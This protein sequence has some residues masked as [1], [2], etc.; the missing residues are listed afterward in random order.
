[1]FIKM[2]FIQDES[3][4]KLLQIV[5]KAPIVLNRIRLC[6][7]PDSLKRLTKSSEVVDVLC[8][9]YQYLAQLVILEPYK[10]LKH[11]I[12]REGET[13]LLFLSCQ[14]GG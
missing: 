10:D 3:V 13:S 2:K 4:R 14:M 8:R 9:T 1:M 5:F 6:R 7:H 12:Q 11:H